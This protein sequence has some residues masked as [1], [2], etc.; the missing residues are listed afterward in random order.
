MGIE[1]AISYCD[2]SANPTM[3]CT[4]CELY[5]SHCYA[6]GLCNRWAGRKGYPEVFTH[7]EY[8][9]GRIEKALRWR[10]LTGTKRPDKPWLDDLPRIIFVDDMGD[11]FC[12][13][14]DPELW[15][16]PHLGA[17]TDSR[18]IWL[19]LTKWPHRMATFFEHRDVPA[20]FWLG[21][22]VLRWQDLLRIDE[23]LDIPAS[24][25]FAS[26]EPMLSRIVFSPYLSLDQWLL[27]PSNQSGPAPAT[28]DWIAAG[29]ESGHNRRHTGIGW[30]R[31]LRDQCQLSGT[32]F[33]LKQRDIGGKI[34]HMPTLDGK[35]WAQMPEVTPAMKGE[36]F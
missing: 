24:V 8:F 19:L 10:D 17:M 25:H 7:P 12:P 28:L 36:L 9:P 34:V 16:A 33:F 2:S 22:S 35:L 27:D 26:V 6:F 15:L 30:F 3:G 31:D 4:G 20:N 1:T 18:H 11:G 32:P 21:T 14:V 13:D 23:L 5:P 29:C